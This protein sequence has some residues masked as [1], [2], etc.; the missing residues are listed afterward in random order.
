MPVLPDLIPLEEAQ[1]RVLV[2]AEPLPA[3]SST[4]VVR[5]VSS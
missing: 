1:D 2:R 3:E 5:P 4:S